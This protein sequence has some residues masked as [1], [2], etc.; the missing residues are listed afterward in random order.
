MINPSVTALLARSNDAVPLP[1]RLRLR[2]DCE[3]DGRDRRGDD[4]GTRAT[5]RGAVR[6][7]LYTATGIRQQHAY[8]SGNMRVD[9]PC[10]WCWCICWAQPCRSYTR[11]T[12][13]GGVHPKRVPVLARMVSKTTRQDGTIYTREG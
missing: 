1:R 9:V 12:R 5:R 3:W 4:G 10:V 6:G 13:R 11:R 2:L 7:E 8:Q